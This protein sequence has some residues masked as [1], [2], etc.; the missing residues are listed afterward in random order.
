MCKIVTLRD[1][2]VAWIVIV[3]YIDTVNAVIVTKLQCVA[4]LANP[5]TDVLT[6][7][8]SQCDS[9]FGAS[10]VPAGHIIGF[11]LHGSILFASLVDKRLAD[12][13]GTIENPPVVVK[14]R[15]FGSRQILNIRPFG[16]TLFS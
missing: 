15:L 11:D 1:E 3:A 5:A 6:I 12:F 7:A 10:V 8:V 9:D 2:V 16:I 14:I 13:D 4:T